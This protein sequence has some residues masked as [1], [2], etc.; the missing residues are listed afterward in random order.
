MSPSLTFTLFITGA[1]L[2][3]FGIY[4]INNTIIQG[5]IILITAVASVPFVY[6]N[7]IKNPSGQ[8]WKNSSMLAI[9]IIISFSSAAF[10]FFQNKA[11]SNYDMNVI[12]NEKIKCTVETASMGR[13]SHEIIL[14]SQI[15]GRKILISAYIDDYNI[16]SAEDEI[17]L[18]T[19]L[20][21]I[22]KDKKDRNDFENRLLMRGI[23]YTAKIRYS[24][25][26]IIKKNQDSFRQKTLD[27]IYSIMDKI[28]EKN[29]SSFLKAL[30]FG[31]KNFAD[32]ETIQ[33]FKK[34]GVL[35]IL[36]ASGFNVAIIA[37]AP[38]FIFSLI[39][40][41]KSISLAAALAAVCF[42]F[43]LSEMPVSLLRACVMFGIFTF[44]FSFGFDKN[45]FNTLFLSA[46][47]ILLLYQYELF[48]P[49]FQ[50]T[51]AATFGII[52]FYNLYRESLAR[53]PEYIRNSA[54]VT[55]SAQVFVLPIILIQMGQIN[56][57]GIATNLIAIP[58]ITAAI[59]SSLI[60][61]II[62]YISP[63]AAG[64]IGNATD[65]ILYINNGFIIFMAE[66]NWHFYPGSF[67]PLL[68]ISF[69][70]TLIPLIPLIKT[71][72]AAPA[73]VISGFYLMFVFSG[74]VS[75]EES[76]KDII[77][78]KDGKYAALI[79][80]PLGYTLT[81]DIGEYEFSKKI[82]DWINKKNINRIDLILS[83]ADYKNLNSY[84]YISKNVLISKCYLS[85]DY[86]FS[87]SLENF[88]KILDTDNIHL[89]TVNFKNP[90]DYIKSIHENYK[91]ISE[92]NDFS[93]INAEIISF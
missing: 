89:E 2:L 44:Q 16:I 91:K 39:R 47:I 55:L 14:S 22:G 82:S 51:Y 54:A 18:K 74:G 8:T 1:I 26:E 27:A 48:N 71:K 41:N 37:A 38:L 72:T 13:Y 56:L 76:R 67:N 3:S 25:I 77:F 75:S 45:I 30:Y 81:G 79:H 52:L 10:I 17:I 23:T 57:A 53:L 43:Y 33:N 46:S 68:M 88:L 60:G 28:F 11:I 78:Q 93:H 50:L 20:R 92:N 7:S 80:G 83:K 65:I 61:I 87:K 84:S 62:H 15:N 4:S 29:S 42:Y 35:H 32:K 36:A 86:R 85:S 31:N 70:L 90:P 73:A 64:I 5:I 59:Y 21:Y 63:F 34:A 12:S 6:K 66:R 69:F 49:G 9:L 58:L 24:D 19:K 40:L